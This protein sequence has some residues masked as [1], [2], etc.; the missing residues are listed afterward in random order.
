MKQVATD[1]KLRKM[2]LYNLDIILSVEYRENSK[3]ATQFRQWA[4]QRLKDYLVQGYAINQ[5]RLEE[6]ESKF[7]KLKQAVKLLES[8]VNT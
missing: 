2:K 4:T 7:Q 8:V 1:G 3:S 6:A 5:K